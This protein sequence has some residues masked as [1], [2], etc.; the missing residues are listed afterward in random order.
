MKC[1]LIIAVIAATLVFQPLSYISITA[2]AAGSTANDAVIELMTNLNIMPA[3]SVTGKFWDDAFV[4]RR[5]VASILC[6]LLNIPEVQPEKSSFS[7]VAEKDWAF[8]YIE[9]VVQNGYMS[10]YGGAR[11]GPD[12]LVT[13]EQ[14]VKIFVDV[15]GYGPFAEQKGGY[16]FGYM[17]IASE[18]RLLAR[19]T[20]GASGFARRIDVANIIYNTMN[21]DTPVLVSA[22]AIDRYTTYKNRTFLSESLDIYRYEGIVNKTN[23]TSL[24][25]ETGIAKGLVQ[26]G[27]GVYKDNS[28]LAADYLGY[29]VVVYVKQAND[30]DY[31]T[32]IS[33][34]MNNKNDVITVQERDIS[35]DGSDI[36]YVNE[37]GKQIKMPI[38][39]GADMVYNGKAIPVD[40]N[41]VLIENGTITFI[42]NDLDGMYDVLIIKEFKT[43]IVDEVYYENERIACRFMEGILDLSNKIYSIYKDGKLIT[44]EDIYKDDVLLVAESE[45]TDFNSVFRIEVSSNSTVSGTVDEVQAGAGRDKRVSI[46]GVYYDISVYFDRLV[47]RGIME[48]FLPGDTG[49]FYVDAYGRIVACSMASNNAKYGY[50]IK[51]KPVSSLASELLV[52]MYCISEGT[53]NTFKTADSL[54]FNGE[55]RRT[56]DLLRLE[57]SVPAQVEAQ[58][59][60][61]SVQ[62]EILTELR[63]AENGYNAQ[64]FSLDADGPIT[65]SNLS[66][67]DNKYIL[68]ETNI[69]VVPEPLTSDPADFELTDTT[70]FNRNS[71]DFKL[72]DISEA[73]VPSYAVVKRSVGTVLMENNAYLVVSHIVKGI[74]P[75]TSE[76]IN[77]LYAFTETGNEVR[78]VIADSLDMS[79]YELGDVIQYRIST[80]GILSEAR[81]VF[82]ASNNNFY[83][84]TVYTGEVRSAYGKLL[85]KSGIRLFTYCKNTAIP[86]GANI[87]DSDFVI[88]GNGRPAFRV[89]KSRNTITKIAMDDI[90]L[91]ENVFA[92]IH[93]GANTR[94]VVVYE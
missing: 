62:E 50:L 4:K 14:L 79:A 80:K 49:T 63:F 21:A 48:D 44:L 12:D 45:N 89:N 88:T 68:S 5:E 28:L 42:D 39:S 27:G 26:I 86:S 30:D 9:A 38:S 90:E 69:L 77:I 11:F 83:A 93:A 33:V 65:Y 16:P 40:P 82:K 20:A 60:Q 22:G 3:E 72:Y 2:S 24:N 51:L 64:L 18:L 67:W 91:F 37:N 52:Q 57:F 55:R 75:E 81:T 41:R 46:E 92:L 23:L 7:D 71:Y 87:T 78:Y 32:I 17:L 73:G 6:A 76:K 74:D 47:S 25:K 43:Y 59:V 85:F 29:N 19:V 53:V 94:I 84:P 66:V 58:L 70:A 15:A 13:V 36:Y 31:G 56:S 10:G 61:Y 35:T 34:Q 1:K 54:V 8:G